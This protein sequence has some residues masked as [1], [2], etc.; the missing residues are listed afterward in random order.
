MVY[1]PTQNL[2]I[3]MALNC[4]IIGLS[5]TGKTTIFNC[6]SNTK[7]ESSNY[8]FSATKS[9]IG[10]VEVPDPRLHE[11]DKLI[12]SEKVVPAMVE[13]EDLPGLAK[14]ANQGEGVGNKFL[15]DIQQT[16]VLIHVLRCFDD[17]NLAHIE[18]SIDPLRDLE[19]VNFELQIRDL[20]LVER[21][22]IRLEK[23]IKSGD[24]DAKKGIEVLN[25]YKD[26]FENFGNA[27]D[28]DLSDDERSYVKELQLLTEKIVIYVCNVDDESAISG[29]KYTKVVKDELAKSSAEF[30]IIAG[31]LEAEIAEL[32]DE[33][34]RK[35]FLTDAGLKE[36]GVNKLIR[37]AYDALNLQSFFTAGP[38]EVKA[39][40]IRKGMTA[41]QAS[42]VI[43]SDLE[44]GFIRAEVMKYNDFIELGSEQAV[45]DKG[46]FHVEGKNYIV[47]DGDIMHIRFNV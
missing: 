38:K 20:D 21:K 29:N 40:T 19:I 37:A 22:I 25:K 31:E 18:G 5:N 32:E 33:N 8:A 7:A 6:M 43:H 28:I 47:E 42:G 10:I 3:F 23:L 13:I 27:R 11:I 41:P 45:K 1:L 24:K 9:N 36:P 15:A 34:D 4:G 16:D 39:W 35:E 30:S 17:E 44:R 46:R 14:G 2:Q 26:H 12:N